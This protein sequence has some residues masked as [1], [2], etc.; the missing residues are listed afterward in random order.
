MGAA[1]AIPDSAPRATAASM[2][3][4]ISMDLCEALLG[5]RTRLLVVDIMRRY[6]CKRG[7]AMHAV[8]LARV[9]VG[10]ERRHGH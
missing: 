10:V 8:A 5:L 3:E 9:R 6:R 4:R 2:A 1:M 7:T